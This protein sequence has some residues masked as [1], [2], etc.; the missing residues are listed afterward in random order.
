[1]RYNIR[2]T[3]VYKEVH[4]YLPCNLP[5]IIFEHGRWVPFGP[6]TNSNLKLHT[7]RQKS[8]LTIAALSHIFSGKSHEMSETMENLAS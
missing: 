4:A 1:M 2:Q 7:I 3:A 8:N 6:R 5:R